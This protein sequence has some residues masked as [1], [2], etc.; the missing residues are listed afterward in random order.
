MPRTISLVVSMAAALALAA[1]GCAAAL[2]P[3]RFAPPGT[4]VARLRSEFPLT[5]AERLALTP[6]TVERADAG[7]GRSDLRAAVVRRRSPT[8][9]FAA[10]CSFRAIATAT[11][12]SAT[13][14]IRRAPTARRMSPRCAPS[15]LGRAVLEAARCSSA[16]RAI[17]RNRIEDLADS[18]A[19]H[20]RRRHDSEADVRRR[21]DVAAVS[22][23]AVVRREP[24]RSD[25]A[26]RS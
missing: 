7:P 11:R 8:V 22:G 1:G 2:P 25:A 6:E 21:D 17:L 14:P 9:R 18:A 16:R 4:D 3:I 26:R 23:A 20:R 12:A 13:S 15:S 10:I 19:D 24:A 5:D